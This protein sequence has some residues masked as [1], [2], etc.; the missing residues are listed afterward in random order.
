[1]AKMYLLIIICIMLSGPIA[2]GQGSVRT[3]P[4]PATM[5]DPDIE[6][7]SAHNLGVAWQYFKL[8]KAYVA[9]LQ[10]CQEIIAGNPS[11]TKIDEVLYIAGESSLFLAENKGK[12]SPSLYMTYDG[13][14]NKRTL[15]P[16][17][18]R[19]IGREYLT[20]LVNDFPDSKFRKQAKESLRAVGGP[21]SSEEN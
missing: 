11:F 6:K 17:E 13:N 14:G 10:R 21:K 19:E 4:D 12:Q 8:R 5:R 20:R 15:T 9:S 16:D 7:D 3:S 1:M 2:Y 18:F